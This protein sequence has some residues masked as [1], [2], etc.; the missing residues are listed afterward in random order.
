M[1]KKNT[2]F[3]SLKVDALYEQ[4]RDSQHFQR[5]TMIAWLLLFR[6]KIWN[7]TDLCS[8]GIYLTIISWIQ[9]V[10]V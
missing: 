5:I 3:Y 4:Q 10:M 8:H 1:S 2:K 6:C 9:R 7:W